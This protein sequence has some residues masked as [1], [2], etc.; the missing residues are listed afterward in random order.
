MSPPTSPRRRPRWLGLWGVLAAVALP[1]CATNPN[2]AGVPSAAQDIGT[3]HRNLTL[4]DFY[5]ISDVAPPV[6]C[7]SPH[8]S[9][10]YYVGTVT[11]ALEAAKQRP[12]IELLFHAAGGLCPYQ[13]VLRHLGARP[14]DTYGN[15]NPMARFPTKKEW[16]SGVRVVRCDLVPADRKADEPPRLDIPLRDIMA[17]S[18]SARFRVCRNGS[19]QLPCSQPHQAESVNLSYTLPAQP[20]YSD[21][22]G[23]LPVSRCRPYVEEFLGTS[24]RTR[25]DLVVLPEV[26]LAG[27]AGGVIPTVSC[28][29]GSK[30]GGKLTGTLAPVSP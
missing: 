13:P 25:P 20:N 17:T 27:T 14:R 22:P 15:L 7:N 5:S 8:Q 10:T 6:P 30:A 29:V 26:T 28:W 18:A 19:R 12:S 2:I 9:E 1:A 3:C 24:L 11:G 4:D 21:T 23:R 16:A